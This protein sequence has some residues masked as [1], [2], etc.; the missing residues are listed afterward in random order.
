MKDLASYQGRTRLGAEP[1]A[2]P[3]T[4]APSKGGDSWGG[5]VLRC[6]ALTQTKR[7]RKEFLKNS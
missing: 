1:S 5:G 4:R 3:P 6:I 2:P 7:L